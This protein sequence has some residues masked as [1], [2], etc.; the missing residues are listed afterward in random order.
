MRIGAS[1]CSLRSWVW[2]V[3]PTV[4]CDISVVVICS[5][6]FPALIDNVGPTTV[7][8]SVAII[9]A[10]TAWL[11]SLKSTYPPGPRPL[12][13]LGSLLSLVC[14]KNPS[15]F[16][17][18]LGDTYGPVCLLWIGSQPIVL[19]NSWEVI[20]EAFISKA[21]QFCDRPT[22]YVVR[23]S[24]KGNSTGKM[25][26]INCERCCRMRNCVALRRLLAKRRQCFS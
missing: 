10:T 18:S 20:K 14:Q 15:K 3:I 11:L 19:L 12:P 9:L 4:T 23:K 13:I 25:N 26:G 1:A 7:F 8:V 6:D 24:L 2:Y 5:M 21:G 17:S 16:M 22:L